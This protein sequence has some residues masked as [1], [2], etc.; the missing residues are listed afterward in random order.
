VNILIGHAG[1]KRAIRGPFV[2]YI[3]RDDLESLI[4]QLQNKL[5]DG[6]HSGWIEIT[7]RMASIPKSPP[8]RWGDNELDEQP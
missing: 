1:V 6:Y 4:W 5:D 7:D 3:A 2:I 8:L